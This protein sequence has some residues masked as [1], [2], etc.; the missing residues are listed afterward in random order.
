MG[1][2]GLSRAQERMW[3]LERLHPHTSAY[4]VASA[5]RLRGALDREALQRAVETL[6]ERHS[7]LRSRFPLVGEGPACEVERRWEIALERIEPDHEWDWQGEDAVPPGVERFASEAFDLAAGPLVRAG[8]MTVTADDHVFVLVLHHLV[9]DGWSLGVLHTELAALY[10]GAV[11]GEPADL[12]PVGAEYGDHVRRECRELESGELDP[13]LAYWLRTLEGVEPLELP[14]DRPRPARQSLRGGR[15]IDYLPLSVLRRLEEIARAHASSL[16][17]VLQTAFAILLHRYSGQADVAVGAPVTNRKTS[18]WAGLVGLF[19]NTVVLRGRLSGDASFEEL[20]RRCRETTL[21]ALE[22]GDIPFESVVDCLR[23]ERSLSRNPLFQV[24]FALQG[25][26][27]EVPAFEGLEATLLDPDLGSTRFD[28]ECTT[29]RER[30]RLKVR[31]T[32]SR[33]LFDEATARRMLAHYLRLLERISEAPGDPVGSLDLLAEDER[34]GLRSRGRA[35]DHP[36]L[37]RDLPALFDRQVERAPDALALETASGSLTYLQLRQAAERV[38]ASL[39]ARGA[40]PESVIAVRASRGVEMVVAMLAVMKSGAGLL[41]LDPS[42]P[43][44][45]A[46]HLI[47]DA[48]ARLALTD[49]PAHAVPADKVRWVTVAEANAERRE[50]SCPEAKANRLAYV[51]YTSGSSG[52]PKGVLVEHRNAVNTLV[53][54]REWFGFDEEDMFLCIASPT[55][56][57]FFFEL[58]GPLISGAAVRLVGREELFDPSRLGSILRRATVM[59]AVPS[60]MKQVVGLL[61]AEGAT[62]ERMRY[63]ITGGDVVPARLPAAIAAAFPRAQ[64]AIL[65]GPTETAMVCSGVKLDD[66]GAVSGHPIGGPLPNAE[67][68]VCDGNGRLVP[69]GVAG[70]I[71][72]GGPGVSR[73]YLAPTPE[74]AARFT[75][76]DG[77]RFYRSGDRGRWRNDGEME[78]LGRLDAQLKVRGFRIEPGEIEAALESHPNVRE[79]AVVGCGEEEARRLA[80][81]A[82][83]E[84][85]EDERRAAEARHTEDW[86]A[87]FDATHDSS[88]PLEERHDFTGW[89]SS[90]TREALPREQMEDWL[91]ASLDQIRER[92]PPERRG[93]TRILEIG[94]GTGLLLLELAGE[95]ERYVGTDFSQAVLDGLRRRIFVRGLANVELHRRTAED[96]GRFEGGSFDAVVVNSLVQYLP[97]LERLDEVLRRSLRC[98]RPGGFL[99]VGDVRNLRLHE[100]FLAGLEL[101]FGPAEGRRLQERVRRRREEERE[102]LIA[103]DYFARLASEEGASHVDVPLRR[104]V[105]DNE[106]TRYRYDAVLYAAGGEGPR[107]VPEWIDWDSSGW[108]PA[109]LEARLGEGG[110]DVLGLRDVANARLTADLEAWAHAGGEPRRPAENPVHPERLRRL[111]DRLGYDLA[112]SWARSSR[113]GRFDAVLSK[114]GGRAEGLPRWSWPAGSSS[115]EPANDPAGALLANECVDRVRAFLSESLPAY[116]VP[117][118]IEAVDSLPTAHNGKVDRAALEQWGEALPGNPDRA[119]GAAMEM[120]ATEVE[121]AIAAAWEA[122]L[123]ISQPARD[124]NFFAS[125]GT[126][127][128]AI[129]VAVRLKSHGIDVSAEEM[130]RHQTIAGLAAAVE[131]PDARREGGGEST[132]PPAVRPGPRVSAGRRTAAPKLTEARRVLLTGATGFLG[133]H[134]LDELLERTEAAVI[135]FV[136]GRDDSHA[137]ERLADR[138]GWYF[139]GRELPADRVEV[140]AGELGA[141][142]LGVPSRRWRSLADEA[143]HVIHAAAD[144]RHVA[145]ETEVFRTN[146]DGTRNVIE[147]AAAGRATSLHHVSTVGVKGVLPAADGRFFTERDLDIGQRPTEHY[148][149]SKLAAERVAREFLESGGAGSVLRVGTIAPHSTSGRFQRNA[150]DHFLV[151]Y[152]RSTIELGLASH[153]PGRSFA[154][155]PVDSLATACVA[156]A[157]VAA[158]GA[159]TFHL[160]SP[161]L[162]SHYDLVRFLQGLGYPI[163]LVDP[164]E[165]ATRAWAMARDPRYEGAVGGVL[166]LIDRPPGEHVPLDSS[167]TESKLRDIGFEFPPPSASWFLRFVE[168]CVG[169]GI[170]PAPIH[171]QEVQGLPDVLELNGG[172][173]APGRLKRGAPEI[174]P[175]G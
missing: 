172:A 71:C 29:W 135:C 49:D 154:L 15:H 58:L 167:W 67:L 60:L 169:D 50:F 134:L 46:R 62:A 152:L 95:C 118:S 98:L 61:G 32:Y 19:V 72:I 11:A 43:A 12:E 159:D 17:M 18:D 23:P 27:A 104:G 137:L 40:G 86:R 7:A 93:R 59:Q 77:E 116:M 123:G 55:F 31:L 69:R 144:V 82:V 132:E 142:K 174:S 168:G 5:F 138:W 114:R 147:L 91:R 101:S 128:L 162:L 1:T 92:L 117:A 143:E 107:E 48:G 76:L 54:C 106:L 26:E 39:Q 103:P 64:V 4:N 33:D 73:G 130:F 164:A 22:H 89:R 158:P 35:L 108:L 90:Y 115:D 37:R 105:H 13:G 156:L 41:P 56:D 148:S 113:R 74:L 14:Y 30:R 99:F 96:L 25:A 100:P 119:S 170:L 45:R 129:R 36:D 111:A 136:R 150:E 6:V 16:F 9:S 141:P 112:T 175:L 78:F 84:H 63:A 65:Y 94:C 20:L 80:A 75:E 10:N 109:D 70:E 165:F 79:A 124:A 171:W 127:L 121:I 155:L 166:G 131:R 133:A 24:M 120:P 44:S 153:W 57:I 126:S 139:D 21:D 163:R 66:P 102:L 161:H 3:F 97:G 173:P 28:L 151:R 81:F 85:S 83:L 68:R 157:D 52:V 53:G 87:L 145:A 88:G 122:V 47:A 110:C 160:A 2:R 8:L 38:A 51:I 42:E 146:L 34:R 149:A 140:V 125:G